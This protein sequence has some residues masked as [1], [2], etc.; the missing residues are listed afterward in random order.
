MTDIVKRLTAESHIKNKGHKYSKK[1]IEIDHSFHL[2]KKNFTP[3]DS[4]IP[5]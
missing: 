1:T 3:W 5:T 4:E 2:G